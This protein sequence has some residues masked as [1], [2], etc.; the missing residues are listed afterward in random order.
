MRLAECLRFSTALVLSGLVLS[1]IP[2]WAEPPEIS[3]PTHAEYRIAIH[4]GR[5]VLQLWR[6]TELVREYPIETGK[7]GL[8][9]QR[10][11]DHRTPIGDYEISW[12]A[13]RNPD[14]GH[15][16]V[17]ER[18]WCRGNK[19]LD[20][21]TGPS[22]EKL[23][24]EPYGGDEAAVMSINYPNAKELKKGYTG[25][26]I[27]IHSDKRAQDGILLKSY[28]CIHMFPKDANELYEVVD[29]GTPVKILP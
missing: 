26:C 13:S 18:S 19:F 28:G 12:M 4:C 23:W 7:G 22:L 10:G 9:K 2:A 1:V 3:A 14:K 17:D 21:G 20:A 27:H 25:E 15:R 5:K 24:S 29:V 16:I 8:G 6:Y 11:G